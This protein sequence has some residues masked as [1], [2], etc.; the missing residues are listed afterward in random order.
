MG[1]SDLIS[2]KAL[3]GRMKKVAF[4]NIP[5]GSQDAVQFACQ[6]MAAVVYT[7]PRCGR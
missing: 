5:V 4:E 3:L 1:N 2:R 7:A 6:S